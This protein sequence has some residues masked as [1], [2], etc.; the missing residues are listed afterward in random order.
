MDE[1]YAT[2]VQIPLKALPWEPWTRFVGQLAGHSPYVYDII[3]D[4]LAYNPVTAIIEIGTM[5]G[6]LSMYLGL[7]GLRLDIPVVTFDIDQHMSDPV[8]PVLSAIDVVRY[9]MDVFSDRAVDIIKALAQE[10]VYL[11]CDGGD[12]PRELQT[13][14]PLLPT[15]SVVSVHDWGEEITELRSDVKMHFHKPDEWNAHAANMATFVKIGDV[16]GEHG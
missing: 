5:Y 11:I 1:Y 4:V 7:W 15:R 16:E 12:K 10:P 8:E 6:A 14:A 2:Q 3:S 9:E 13:F